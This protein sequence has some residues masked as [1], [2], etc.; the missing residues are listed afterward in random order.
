MQA[1]LVVVGGR[2]TKQEVDVR[3]P[4]AIGRSDESNLTIEH[5]SISRQHCELLERNG[6]LVVRDV[7]SANGTYVGDRQISGEAVLEPGDTFTVGPLTFRA[8]YEVAAATA[9]PVAEHPTAGATLLE[10]DA[11]T[12]SSDLLALPDEASEV[13]SF[14]LELSD[15]I[16]LPEIA[17][18][19][20]EESAAPSTSASPAAD[21]ADLDL[22]LDDS[23]DDLRLDDELQEESLSLP[24]DVDEPPA[25]EVPADLAAELDLDLALDLEPSETIQSSVK[26]DE[27]L[28]LNLDLDDD[29]T[30]EPAIA[31]SMTEDDSPTEIGEYV[32]LRG[33]DESPSAPA[34]AVPAEFQELSDVPADLL[35]E[36]E[37]QAPAEEIEMTSLEAAAEA[38]EAPAEEASSPVE[39]ELSLR[40]FSDFSHVDDAPSQ[41][42]FLV[43][44]EEA[45]HLAAEIEP[46]DDAETPWVDLADELPASSHDSVAEPAEEPAVDAF[47]EAL[48]LE[49][50]LAEDE[51]LLEA[52]LPLE[53][54]L[55]IESV[56]ENAADDELP[57][58]DAAA[59]ELDNLLLEEPLA[60]PASSEPLPFE[61]SVAEE[62]P[63]AP[64]SSADDDNDLALEL[65]D[66]LSLDEEPAS[67]VA[68]S[69]TSESTEPDFTAWMFEESLASTEETPTEVAPQDAELPSLDEPRDELAEALSLDAELP[70]L[71]AAM[72]AL[73]N[74]LPSLEAESEEIEFADFP[75]DDVAPASDAV[76]T[77]DEQPIAA[78]DIPELDLP[79]VEGSAEPSAEEFSSL[80]ELSFEEELDE[81][82]VAPLE[83]EAAID[84]PADELNLPATDTSATAEV[85][86]T[87]DDVSFDDWIAAEM[88]TRP[89]TPVEEQVSLEALDEPV[90]PP[91]DEDSSPL[92]ADPDSEL[93][94]DEPSSLDEAISFDEVPSFDDGPKLE[95]GAPVDEDELNFED[96]AAPADG[97][98]RVELPAVF[99]ESASLDLDAPENEVAQAPVE[100]PPTEPP[101]AKRSWWPFGRNREP[102][103]PKPAKA[104]KPAKGKKK[105]ENQTLDATASFPLDEAPLEEAPLEE[106]RVEPTFLPDEIEF[107]LDDGP[108]FAS[109]EPVFDELTNSGVGTLPSEPSSFAPVDPLD[110][111][112]FPLD[113]GGAEV[114]RSELSFDEP[115]FE[116]PTFDAPAVQPSAHEAAEF[117]ELSFEEPLMFEEESSSEAAVP[118]VFD[119]TPAT[120]AARLEP[121]PPTP[122]AEQPAKARRGWWPFGRKSKAASAAADPAPAKPSR[123]EKKKSRDTLVPDDLSAADLDPASSLVEESDSERIARRL[124]G[125][126]QPVDKYPSFG[127]DLLEQTEASRPASTTAAQEE[128]P[129]FDLTDEAPNFSLDE[130]A[131]APSFE[132][133]E[134][135]PEFVDDSD[136]TTTANKS[137]ASGSE[138]AS[139]KP[140]AWTDRASHGEARGQR[141][142]PQD[143]EDDWDSFLK[144][145]DS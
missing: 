77:F 39:G 70:S 23:F 122:A 64:A 84:I 135:L 55:E 136:A 3:L 101:K 30:T 37:A 87:S 2:A 19:D 137:R 25:N 106:A 42:L 103:P 132:M 139:S 81:A 16:D 123:A 57:L 97:H 98:E 71:D 56:V 22:P 76:A 79:G 145:F 9:A 115:K 105:K 11:A 100:L 72:P 75:S 32:D 61:E 96:F 109:D 43:D 112:S 142:S 89:A 47:E 86:A 78:S 6:R 58:L 1:K 104:P 141:R 113:D 33:E 99:E 44:G 10:E 107:S 48:P 114:S 54:E 24:L 119:D 21:A 117:E 129:A 67:L 51:F 45:S 91:V 83:P 144:S 36:L 108:Q 111:L 8:V 5:R 130:E 17:R 46:S 88:S 41:E 102:K 53:E 90:F 128:L 65:S 4:F 31:S 7:G 35:A 68:A 110:E 93:N 26:S 59:P 118:P 133:E 85:E 140:D 63:L 13:D 95:A 38:P 15:D 127:D 50:P 138:G 121:E 82:A 143:P 69:P 73:G 20:F 60:E 80:D 120:P 74:D 116:E 134:E 28:E 125:Q 94:F 49:A 62:A 131:E 34:S 66:E 92:S 27:S 52:S 126:P 40:D 14:D 12:P 29:F 18:G 124:S